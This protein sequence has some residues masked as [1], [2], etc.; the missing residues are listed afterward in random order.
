MKNLEKYKEFIEYEFE[1]IQGENKDFMIADT[2]YNYAKTNPKT[3]VYFL[4]RDISHIV[5]KSKLDNFWIVTEKDIY[6]H[7]QNQGKEF[8]VEETKIFWKYLENNN[9]S[10]IIRMDLKDVDISGIYTNSYT[11]LCYA[12]M[13]NF[14]DIAKYLFLIENIDLNISGSM[15]HGYGALH[16]AVETNNKSLVDK[17]I[18]DHRVN[19]NLLTKD[20]TINNVTP[21]MIASM[22]GNVDIVE[23]FLKK[24]VS[25]NQQDSQGN[26]AVHKAALRNKKNTYN[27]LLEISDDLIINNEYLRAI[28]IWEKNNRD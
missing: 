27:V 22:K 6:K 28:D 26:T 9:L 11:P 17:F 2:I 15:P 21:L 18:N 16:C 1:E 25:V 23:M 19:I 13:K 3:R 12:I 14:W 10:S 24:E 7:L 4:S 5:K 8:N 20:N